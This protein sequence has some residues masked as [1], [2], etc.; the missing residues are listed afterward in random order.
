MKSTTLFGS[1]KR[2]LMISF[3]AGTLLALSVNSASQS[4]LAQ[5]PG[6]NSLRVFLLDAQ[7]LEL[8]KQRVRAGDKAL[9]QA[10]AQL[11]QDAQKAL[12]TGPFSVVTKD[13]VPPSGDKHDYMSQA[14]YFWPDSSKPKGLP[15]IRR[16]GERNPE[17][18]KISDH[19]SLD[20]MINAVETLALAYYYK[21]NDA[22]AARAV[23][24][25]RAFFLDP[26]TRM[27]P[28]LQFAQFIPG[29]NT[30]RGIGL[31]ETRGLTRVVDA[32]GLLSGSQALTRKD[33]QEL[34]EWFAKFL[35]WMLESKNGRD[36][37]AAKNN[38][39]TYYDLQV[40]SFALFLGR[41]DLARDT[42]Q[43]ARQK[44]IAAQIEPDGRQPLELARTKAWSYSVGNLD[45]LMLLAR[46]GENVG[47]DLWSYQAADGRSIRRALD[48]LVPFALGEQKWSYQQLGEWPPEMLFPLLRRAASKYN[49][50]QF[51]ARAARV[52]SLKTSDRALLLFADL[53]ETRQAQR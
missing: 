36:E 18:N 28:H 7:H 4:S 12:T 43:T 51:Q 2:P 50:P 16:D 19:R 29:V 39:G 30:G 1:L 37:S 8:T 31:I 44:R 21:G 26:A 42:L 17:I 47:V 25:L 35:G 3:V 15:Y 38:H 24:L 10:V 40:T 9:A 45:G 41:K 33:E 27:N 32:I 6:G 5:H 22:Y 49:D 52:P 23:Q 13:L 11:D 48:Y 34:Q 20:Q 53:A 14:P 46:L